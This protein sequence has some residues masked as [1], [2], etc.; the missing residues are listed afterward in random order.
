M[1]TSAGPLAFVDRGGDESRGAR[2]TETTGTAG[3]RLRL[4]RQARGFSQQQLAGM[5]GVSRQAV[6]AVEAGLSDPSLR[7]ALAVGRALGLSVEELFG[8]AIP[9]PVVPVRP[10]APVGSEGSR[11]SP[12]PAAG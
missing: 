4:A 1:R 11:V 8:P 5:A 10:L 12:P 6:S 3:P 9:E 2:V 7:V